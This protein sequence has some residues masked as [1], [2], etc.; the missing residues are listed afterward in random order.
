MAANA[1]RKRKPAALKLLEGTGNGRDSGGRKVQAGPGFRRLPPK[2]PADMSPV[3]SDLWD[4][5]VDELQRL[6]LTKPVDGPALEMLCE[7]YSRWHQARAM[8]LAGTRMIPAAIEDENG[9][10][11]LIPTVEGLL[12][13]NSQG[14]SAAPWIGIEERAAKE[15]RAWCAE[16]GMTPAAEVK[17]GGAGEEADADNPF[18]GGG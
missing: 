4:E 5:M 11:M 10:E 15:Y 9:A 18:D 12:G 7:A 6:Q 13:K 2:K 17:V 16:F 3:A 1:G 8:R 14:W